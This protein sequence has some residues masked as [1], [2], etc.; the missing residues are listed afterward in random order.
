MDARSPACDET[1]FVV[2]RGL[3]AGIDCTCILYHMNNASPLMGCLVKL[4]HRDV[5]RSLLGTE[6]SCLERDSWLMHPL[7]PCGSW[8]LFSS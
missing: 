6:A 7:A 8:L 3:C 4:P 5:V 1:V 2:S